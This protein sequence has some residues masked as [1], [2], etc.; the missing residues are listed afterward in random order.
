M[1]GNK[2]I[3]L[4]IRQVD[5]RESLRSSSPSKVTQPTREDLLGYMLGALDAP[6]SQ[7][8]EQLIQENPEVQSELESIESM[9]APLEHMDTTVDACPGLAR[10]TVEYVAGKERCQEPAMAY[11][12]QALPASSAG[13]TPS[14]ETASGGGWSMTDM[15][16]GAIAIA[17]LAAVAIP[18]ISYARFNSRLTACQ[19]NLRQ[20]GNALFVYQDSSPAQSFVSIPFCPDDPMNVAGCYAPILKDYGLVEDDSTFFCSGSE[21]RSFDCI[22]TCE[23]I[24]GAIGPQL[25]DYKRNMGGDFGYSLGFY[26]DGKYCSPRG[27]RSCNFAV[28]S[29][30]PSVSLP[31]RQSQNHGGCGQNVWFEDGHIEFLSEPMTPCGD[32]IFENDSGACGPGNCCSDSCIGASYAS[33]VKPRCPLEA[34]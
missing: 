11:S 14:V 30:K 13:M 4:I 33:P 10:R 23:Q 19:N 1:S 24:R 18:T 16:V 34:K 7:A 8:I 6:E 31:G 25:A 17:V 9:M 20:V 32:A 21:S 22:P 27:R 26:K 2:P 5:V 28:L 3:K 12:P 15:L 29:D